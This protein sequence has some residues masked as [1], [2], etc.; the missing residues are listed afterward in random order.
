[1]KRLLMTTLGV[2]L[3]GAAQAHGDLPFK[4]E[5]IASFD[6]PWAMAFL[7][8]GRMLVTEKKG[9]LRIVS[10][11]GQKWLPSANIISTMAFRTSIS[12]AVLTFI[13]IPCFTFCIQAG[14]ALP[15]SSQVQTRQ[16]PSGGSI[17]S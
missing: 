4:V 10:Q 11:A 2:L 9:V 8:D 15:F 7:P 13:S 5:P 12:S 1:M 14:T 3:V 6:E 17:C 16:V